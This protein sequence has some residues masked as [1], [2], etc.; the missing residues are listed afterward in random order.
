MTRSFS[1]RLATPLAALVLMVSTYV[2]SA[3][4]I[5]G[6]AVV[7]TPAPAPTPLPAPTGITATRNPSRPM[8]FTV[9]WKPVAGAVDHYNVSVFYAGQDHVTIVPAPGTS[10][11]TASRSPPATLPATAPRPASSG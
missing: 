3:S 11:S 2:A 9:A 7:P 8:D 6:A 1:R 4:T 5:A 10:R